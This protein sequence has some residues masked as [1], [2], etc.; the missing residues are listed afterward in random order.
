MRL[1]LAGLCVSLVG[2]VVP[3]AAS[4]DCV[5]VVTP[6]ETLTSIA[7]TDGLG[8]DQLAAANGLSPTMRLLAGI[9]LTIPPQ[10]G[11]MTNPAPVLAPAPT[12]ATVDGDG[13]SD[14]LA[15]NASAPA[16]SS[17]G[18]Y[19]VQPGD[20]L[21]AIAARAGISVTELAAANGINAAG[22]LLIGTAL[23]LSGAPAS[24]APAPAS[25]ASAPAPASTSGGSYVVQPGDTLTA[26]AARAGMSVS[27]LAAANG[28]NPAGPLLI[29]TALQVPAGAA[30][31]QSQASSGSPA[32]S[33]PVGAAAEGSAI[34]PPYPTSETVS[35]SEVGSI[36]AANGVPAALADAIAYQESGFNNGL[37]STADARGVMQIL[38][39]TWSW[40]QQSLAPQS[41][42]L[43]P[44]SATD[45]I[46]GGVLLLHSLL[47]ATGGSD[48]MAAA[49]YYQGL[50]SV[51]RYGV[52]P[53][54]Q[55]YVNDVL[56]L[57]QRF[58]G[59]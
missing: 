56:A 32:T 50:P 18:S 59:G 20:T 57:E 10:G 54:T 12:P 21:T 45:N 7:A 38:P 9:C 2:L 19:V 35:P 49:G 41:S 16:S 5:H 52:L 3:A 14:D 22:P 15:S 42:P 36:A 33:Q 13:D 8:I 29:G 28:L 44:A 27:A 39:G 26:I 31:P 6:G 30:L 58:S 46:R 11:G 17:G 53:S 24:A 34:N 40:I 48:A 51:E 37:V 1:R 25:A 23:R 4:A 55:Q 43:A 47:N